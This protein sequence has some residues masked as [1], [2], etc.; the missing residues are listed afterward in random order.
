MP[1]RLELVEFVDSGFQRTHC[2]CREWGAP[3]PGC[4]GVPGF[5]VP[6]FHRPCKCQH[7][8][9][10]VPDPQPARTLRGRLSPCNVA[11]TN[12][13]R[14]KEGLRPHHSFSLVSCYKVRWQ[15]LEC[16][17]HSWLSVQTQANHET[18]LSL[19][20]QINIPFVEWPWES[21]GKSSPWLRG[22]HV[23]HPMNGCYREGNMFYYCQLP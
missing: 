2:L 13:D 20:L 11:S 5:P 17:L 16:Y 14:R 7:F 23:R 15:Q 18:S 10:R 3:N 22:E 21:K 1:K 8:R 6:G 19:N 9:E 12:S 4:L